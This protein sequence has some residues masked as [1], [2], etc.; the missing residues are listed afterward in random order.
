MDILVTYSLLSLIKLRKDNL[1]SL[2]EI[3]QD[4]TENILY[5]FKGNEDGKGLINDLRKEFLSRYSISIPFPTL[6]LILKNIKAEKKSKFSL[7]DDFSFIYD[8][9]C[10]QSLQKDI[11]N[12][13]VEIS[14]LREIYKK[15]C[16]ET[17]I[18]N[19]VGIEY[20]IDINR[21]ELIAYLSGNHN[22]VKESEE[23]KLF[24]TLISIEKYKVII[25]RLIMGSIISTYIELEIGDNVKKKQLLLDTNFI[26]SLF[27]L[28]S[29]ESYLTCKEIVDISRKYR[30]EI[31]VLP[32]T[33]QE[34]RNLLNR[35][36]QTIN[37]IHI[38]MSQNRNTIEFGCSRRNLD[39]GALELYAEKIEKLIMAEG[40]KILPQSVNSRLF[41][42][43]KS[44]EIYKKIK[45]R[46][47]NREGIVH[48]A[49]AMNYIKQIRKENETGFHDTTAF[50]VTDSHGYLE[51]KISSKTRLPYI[52]RA[53]ELLNVMWL[54][55]PT[56][57]SAIT[58]SN[59]ANIFST[60]LNKSLPNREML[61]KLDE[62][63]KSLEG[64]PIDIDDCVNMAVNISL[65]DS[66][67]L[68]D[69]FR[70][71]ELGKLQEKMSVLSA[72]LR[73]KKEDEIRET[74]E[75]ANKFL[76]ILEDRLDDEE[77]QKGRI[78][79][80]LQHAE[81]KARE[82]EELISSIKREQ[83]AESERM[84]ND[85]NLQILI[86]KKNHLDEMIKRSSDE[87]EHIEKDIN[88]LETTIGR[89][90]T[91]VIRAMQ[92]FVIVSG[93]LLGVKFIIPNWNLF[94]PITYIIGIIAAV[95]VSL[96]A[97]INKTLNPKKWIDNTVNIIAKKSIEK[98]AALEGR[99]ENLLQRLKREVEDRQNIVL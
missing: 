76:K 40:V 84:E 8:P 9:S 38:F 25:E 24:K 93:A 56:K 65:A 95:Y 98:K 50:F 39:G 72:R 51:N 14:E 26:I 11:E 1:K 46:P 96:S 86:Q 55:D 83:E 94:E 47:F 92:A 97:L 89:R 28:H 33:V 2:I 62:K 23:F 69:I 3:F 16:G 48:D 99:K 64:L 49:M 82:K 34:V 44:S 66:S 18:E 52:I 31:V 61:K 90:R 80:M 58:R 73:R 70:T 78:A 21:R 75:H 85:K 10:F 32:E 71:D 13:Q 19:V 42:N 88:E 41:H 81:N 54:L 12:E 77:R 67:E 68:E 63:I 15:L 29:E 87:I 6:K 57:N 35:K 59:I 36:A 5:D 74:A 30:F 91:L 37:K 60:Y 79:E 4:L 20:F 53:E 22:E 17:K 7:Y 43:V 45:D 27:N